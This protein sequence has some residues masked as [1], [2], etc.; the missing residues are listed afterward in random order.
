[1]TIKFDKSKITALRGSMS[2]YEFGKVIGTSR[3]RIHAWEEGISKPN[4]GVLVHMANTF[5]V[6]ISYFFK[7]VVDNTDEK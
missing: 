5:N 6:P 2:Q 1:M 4:I 7:E 3:Q